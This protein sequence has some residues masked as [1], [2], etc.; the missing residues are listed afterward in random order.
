MGIHVPSDMTVVYCRVNFSVKRQELVPPNTTKTL[1]NPG[2]H[3]E[4]LMDDA[5][6]S[7]KLLFRPGKQY[8]HLTNKIFIKNDCLNPHFNG[9]VIT[10]I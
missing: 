3:H 8:I 1:L 7:Y 2:L 4:I 6:K 9:T 10:N 5:I